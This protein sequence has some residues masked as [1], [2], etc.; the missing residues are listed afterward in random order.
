LGVK[1]RIYSPF[2]SL[3]RGLEQGAPP[4]PEL[5]SDAGS[6]LP[7][8]KVEDFRGLFFPF[9]LSMQILPGEHGLL[10]V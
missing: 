1:L 10:A 6:L 8:S 9:L 7:W 2:Y 4:M 3:S 5:T